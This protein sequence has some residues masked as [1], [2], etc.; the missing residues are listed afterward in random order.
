[1]NVVETVGRNIAARRKEL[2]ISQK[3]L[4]ARLDITQDAMNRIERGR[5]APKMSRLDDIAKALQC[6]VAWLF[7][8]SDAA[9]DENAAAIAN[10]LSGLPSNGQQALVG[11]VAA[12]ANVMSNKC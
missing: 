7:R 8:E 2:G 11:L 5:M 4:A 12:A 10:I 3:E 1:M 6:P 9:S